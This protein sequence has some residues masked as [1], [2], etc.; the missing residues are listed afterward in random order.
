MTFFVLSS[1]ETVHDT[2]QYR[3]CIISL[4]NRLLKIRLQRHNPLR[5]Y[6]QEREKLHCK[7]T[8]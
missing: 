4:L 7:C 6:I 2:V 8:M 1:L 3:Y 5:S